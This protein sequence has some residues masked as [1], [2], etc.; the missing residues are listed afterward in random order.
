MKRW[1]VI[2]LIS[3]GGLCAAA[4]LVWNPDDIVVPTEAAQ[5]PREEAPPRIQ[6]LH[7]A[8]YSCDM[9]LINAFIDEQRQLLAG[10]PE[11][12]EAQRVCAE[13]LLERVILRNLLEGMG[14]G[15]PIHEE[16]P[17]DSAADLEEGLRLV[18]AAREAGDTCSENYRIA[19]A[20]MSNQIT[21]FTS[22]LK[23]NGKIVEAFQSAAAADPNNPALQMALAM[24]KLLAPRMLGHD[25][26]GSL[27]HFEHAAKG[28]PTDERPTLFAAMANMVLEEPDQAIL[29]LEKAVEINPNNLFARAVLVRVRNGEPDPFGRDVTTAEIDALPDR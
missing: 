22:A 14:V 24:R 26:R 20:L 25:A 19:A 10:N 16:L 17:A 2:T 28:M 23:W 7:A 3:L 8:R 5:T 21:G 6:E 11:D 9:S 12:T 29:K 15:K 13:A 18:L 27:A 1:P 4:Y